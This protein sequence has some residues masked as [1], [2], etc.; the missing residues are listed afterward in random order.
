MF[1]DIDLFQDLTFGLRLLRRNPGVSILAIFCLTLGIGAT[2]AVFGWVEGIL[3]RPFPLVAHQERMIALAGTT[4]GTTDLTDVSW[5]DLQDFQKRCTLFDWFIVD[6]ITGTTLST[7]DRAERTLGSVVS[8]NYFDA[9]GVRPIL[10]RG[11]E[12]SED[13]GRNAHAV[14][15]IS[16]Q[17]WR[18]RFHGDPEIIGKTQ[19]LNNQQHTII[20]VAPERFYGTFVGYA[21]QFWVPVSM[22]E[23]FDPTGYKLENRGARWIEGFARLKPGVTLAQAQT[24]ISAVAARLETEYP[25]TNRGWN[26]RLFPLSQTPFNN[27][28]T[29]MPTL[30]I[31]LVVAWFVLLIA[32]ANAGNLLLVRS[33][34]RRHEMSVRLA[35][36]VTRGRLI[37]QLI[38]EGMILSVLAAVG[39]LLIAFL[40]RNLIMLLFPARPGLTVNLPAEIDWR[41]LLLGASVCLI[42]TLLF[43]LAPAIQA[44]RVDLAAA[45][46]NEAGGV[47][48]GSSKTRVRSALVM[49]QVSLSFVLLVGAGLL[50][51]SLQRMRNMSPGFST[52][53]VLT[54]AI[55]LHSAGY[56]S[57]RIKNFQDQLIDRVQ[58]LPGVESAA[59]TRVAP[60]SYPSYSSAPIRVEGYVV[61]PGEEPAIEYDEVGPGYLAAMGIPIVTGREFTR[62][63]NEQAPLV[64]VVNE[65]M[66]AQYWRGEDPVG[67][68]FQVNDRWMQVVGVAKDSKYQTLM[69]TGKPFFY[70]AMRQNTPGQVLQIRTRLGPETMAAALAQQ[71]RALDPNLA[72]YE[73]I[74]MREQVDR[75]TWAHR[76]PLILLAIFGGLA[77][78]MAAIGLYGVMSY[79]VSQSSHELGLRMA[80]GAGT[81]NMVRLVISRGLRLTVGGV[82]VGAGAALLLTRLIGDLLYRVSPR[83]PVA[84]GLA[85]AVMLI[86]ALAACFFP[87]WRAA[88]TDPVR[89]LKD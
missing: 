42:S 62:A 4:R 44:T 61:P 10:G 9:L 84:F 40:S 36:G 17:M 24:E 83:D 50:F 63:D 21:F 39:G 7:G 85:L 73:V 71:V 58:A 22:Q 60:F 27:A 54:T 88:R 81:S 31:A 43:G 67:R 66:A 48:G 8:A 32:C 72:P 49:V 53:G 65:T 13:T 28:G 20:G 75:M 45:M 15:V 47:I 18:D 69:E 82:L 74:T 33:F 64:A 11:F 3:L 46:K 78:V 86:S 30:R 89:A 79:A 70:V 80:L 35:L 25:S 5:P 16:Y 14:T 12:P 51:K 76:A 59:F 26:V 57:Q 19:M 41:V 23:R 77:L 38:T 68:R 87:A 2:T 52:Q 1:Q 29:L 34:A 55:D 37:K 6:R 56:D